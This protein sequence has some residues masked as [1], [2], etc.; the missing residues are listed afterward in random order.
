MSSPKVRIDDAVSPIRD[1]AR[2]RYAR[3]AQFSNFRKMMTFDKILTKVGLDC[4]S[5]E[6]INGCSSNNQK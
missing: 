4:F 1:E 3:D 2:K 6:R 5:E